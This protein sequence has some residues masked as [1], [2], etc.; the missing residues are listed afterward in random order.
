MEELFAGSFE[1]FGALG[2]AES[3]QVVAATA[4]EEGGSGDGGDAGIGEQFACFEGGGF[5]GDGT[6]V[7][8]NVVSSG[9]DGRRESRAGERRAEHVALV[10]I[11]GGELEIVLVG[12]PDEAGGGSML[13]GRGSANVSEVVEVTDGTDKTGVGDEI[14]DAPAGDG[15]GFGE[16]GDGEGALSHAGKSGEADVPGAVVKEVFVDFVGDDQQVML[17]D[18]GGE[19]LELGAGEDFAAGVG[20]RVEDQGAGSRGD[21]IAQAVKVHGPIGFGERDDDRLDALCLEG[22]DMV[23]VDGFEEQD[24]IAGIEEREASGVESAG[25]AGGDE[26]FLLGIGLN[27]VVVARL[28]GHGVAERGDAVQTGVGIVPVMNGG[29]GAF[30]D[31]SWEFGV[32]DALGEIDASKAVAFDGHGADFRLDDEAGDFAEAGMGRGSHAACLAQSQESWAE[33]RN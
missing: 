24:F 13:K 25:G 28:V 33:E 18:E 15:E 10:L 23:P 14:A 4:G 29:Y 9:G 17:G 1:I 26:D 31:R 11:V 8:E 22:A 30:E 3:E 7:G 19:L 32:A 12:K 6:G 2:E 16:A 21:G 20:G 27:A 5:S